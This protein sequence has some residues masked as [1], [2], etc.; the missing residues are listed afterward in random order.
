MRVIADNFQSWQTFDV[1]VE[2]LTVIVGPSNIGKSAIFRALMGVCRNEV[3]AGHIRKGADEAKVTME[4][5]GNTTTVT[6]SAKETTYSVKLAG[7]EKA[8]EFGKLNGGL[9][10][11]MVTWGFQP[12]SVGG[13]TIDPVFASQFD[14]PFLLTATPQERN[15]IFGAFSSTEKLD[16]GRKDIKAEISALDSEAKTLGAEIE[17]KLTEFGG[18]KD[19]LETLSP[20]EDG[21]GE[22][23]GQITD[24]DNTSA[25]LTGIIPTVAALE[26]IHAALDHLDLP[27]PAVPKARHNVIKQLAVL[28]GT[29]GGIAVAKVASKAINAAAQAVDAGVKQGSALTQLA[30]YSTA[31][32]RLDKVRARSEAVQSAWDGAIKASRL[33]KALDRLE[34][35]CDTP[36]M[37][38]E[39]LSATLAAPSTQAKKA[40][41]L[42]TALARITALLNIKMPRTATITKAHKAVEAGKAKVEALKAAAQ[43]LQ[44]AADATAKLSPIQSDLKATKKETATLEGEIL[45]LRQT[46]VEQ[47]I[48]CPKCGTLILAK[49]HNGC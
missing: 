13:T 6:R 14:A 12:V 33:G 22:L 11:A 7:A 32:S 41:A 4:F 20:V 46:I 10:E 43:A 31:V 23:H 35:V 24:L 25:A 1:E 8:E 19:L 42:N 49:A 17:R 21:L 15:A 40:E 26:G 3:E 37:D 27:D 5:E 2:G 36:A 30:T 34:V 47:S 39:A 28:E 44:K 29:L 9:P 18:L 45:Q 48:E 16:A 38:I